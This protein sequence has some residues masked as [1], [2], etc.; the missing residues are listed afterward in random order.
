[1]LSLHVRMVGGLYL[2]ARSNQLSLDKSIVFNTE[3][4]GQVQYLYCNLFN[5]KQVLFYCG[6][7]NVLSTTVLYN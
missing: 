6:L 2:Q 4:V 5:G 7:L 1:M 3:A